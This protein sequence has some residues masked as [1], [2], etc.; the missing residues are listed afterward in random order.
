MKDDSIGILLAEAIKLKL[1]ASGISVVICETN[2]DYA[3]SELI[4]VDLIFIIDSTYYDIKPGTVTVTPISDQLVSNSP[5][6]SQHQL[7]LIDLIKTNKEPIEG[8]II[9]VEIAEIS[10]GIELSNCLSQQ[11][12]QLCNEVFNVIINITEGVKN[13]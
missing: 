2:A 11:F 7:S 13:A 6:Y 4:D 3:L 12:N 5:N 9:G 8:F 10:F 1:I